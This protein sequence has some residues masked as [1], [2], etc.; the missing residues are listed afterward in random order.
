M[1][2]GECEVRFE[3]G[4][5]FRDVC[6]KQTDCRVTT[7]IFPTTQAEKSLISVAYNRISQPVSHAD[8][9]LPVKFQLYDG[10]KRTD[11]TNGT[12]I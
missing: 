2:S 9:D 10:S 1:E 12:E 11:L 7:A 3:R 4:D 5:I 8:R 6:K